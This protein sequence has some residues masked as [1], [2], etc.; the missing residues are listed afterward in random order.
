MV[1]R[2]KAAAAAAAEL[3]EQIRYA[4]TQFP[5][6]LR[7][8]IPFDPG[9]PAQMAVFFAGLYAPAYQ[10][11][12]QPRGKMIMQHPQFGSVVID[13][14]EYKRMRDLACTGYVEQYL[15]RG[16]LEELPGGL[17]RRKLVPTTVHVLDRLHVLTEYPRSGID[18]DCA[19][20]PQHESV[21]ALKKSNDAW[22]YHKRALTAAKLREILA[23][24]PE[25]IADVL[26]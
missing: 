1:I 20:V 26:A 4:M 12:S 3:A 14:A 19:A 21:A 13:I 15:H 6:P 5:P 7:Y 25:A 22:R 23:E 8:M 9:T 11:P 16:I 2:K 24:D 10:Q 17:V 18:G